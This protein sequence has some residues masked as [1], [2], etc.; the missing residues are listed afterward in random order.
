MCTSDIDFVVF[1]LFLR[2]SHSWAGML[3]GYSVS[4]VQC[5]LGVFI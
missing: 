1:T 4:V 2:V 5:R 3:G